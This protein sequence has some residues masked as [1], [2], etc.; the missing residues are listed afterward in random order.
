MV[1]VG[2][3]RWRRLKISHAKDPPDQKKAI[4]EKPPPLPAPIAFVKTIGEACEV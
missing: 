3:S 4:G 1:P 2:F